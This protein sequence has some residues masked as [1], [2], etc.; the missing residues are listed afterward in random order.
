MKVLLALMGG[1]LMVALGVSLANDSLVETEAASEQI[2]EAPLKFY[3]E[4]IKAAMMEHIAEQ[5]DA[6]GVFHLRDVKT[7]EMLSLKFVKIHDP[8]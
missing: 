2:K 3:V 5:V 1:G 4:D 7:G 6:D 8:V